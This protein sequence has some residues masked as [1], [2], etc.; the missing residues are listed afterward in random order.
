MRASGDTAA[1]P[2]PHSRTVL[3]EEDIAAALEVLRSGQVNESEV[4]RELERAAADLLSRGHA[5]ATSGGTAALHSA[6][7]SMGIGSGDE[8]LLPT[9]VCDDVLSAVAQA[10]ATPVPVDLEPDDLNPIPED[11]LGKR[12]DRTAAIVLAHT[13][14]M[15]ARLDEFESL[16][17]PIIEDCAHGLGAE[18]STGAAGARGRCTVL[19]FHG[20]KMVTAGEGGMVLTDDELIADTHHR[21]RYPDFAA[22]EYR[23][24]SRMSNVLAAIALCQLG[25]LEETVS[26]RRAL[27]ESYVEALSGLAHARPVSIAAD[28]G[29]LSS[30][31][32]FALMT[33]GVIPFEELEDRFLEGG[34]IVRRPVK[35][36][37]HRTLALDPSTCPRAEE[38]FDRIV[39]LPLYPSLSTAEQ[40]AVIEAARSILA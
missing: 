34:V 40:G 14:G 24:H 7:L 3:A 16:G 30:C 4:T 33:D 19:S 25:R 8:V 11:A 32:R 10:G 39:S 29:R 18:L 23:L 35:Q 36:L 6:M 9:Y 27:A 17:V 37:C 28:D 20:L 5:W 12:G 21:L 2:V 38:L 13:L 1:A 31:Y 22:G 15:P 26:R